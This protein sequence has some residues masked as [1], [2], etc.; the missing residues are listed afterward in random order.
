MGERLVCNQEVGGS[1]PLGSIASAAVKLIAD[2]PLLLVCAAISALAETSPK[3]PGWPIEATCCLPKPTLGTTSVT[4]ALAPWVASSFI[5]TSEAATA[6]ILHGSQET[7]PMAILPASILDGSRTSLMVLSRH[8]PLRRTVWNALSGA[9]PACG[10]W[11]SECTLLGTYSRRGVLSDTETG[12]SLAMPAAARSGVRTLLYTMLQ[13]TE[14]IHVR[15][16]ALHGATYQVK[17]LLHMF[18]LH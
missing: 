5:L 8:S 16:H 14:S 15:R 9:A 1:S 3:P 7:C 18:T 10:A 11:S 17:L 13:N 12:E 4:T 6:M 2:K